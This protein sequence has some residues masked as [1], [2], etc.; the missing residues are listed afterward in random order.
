MIDEDFGPCYNRYIATLG[1]DMNY[2]NKAEWEAA[3][4]ANGYELSFWGHGSA[5]A[6]DPYDGVTH[7]TWHAAFDCNNGVRA[8]GWLTIP[9]NAV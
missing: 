1:H 2:R 3:V 4:K 9:V 5:N 8:N 7:G 6:V